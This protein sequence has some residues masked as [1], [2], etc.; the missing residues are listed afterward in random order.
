MISQATPLDKLRNVAG[1]PLSIFALST[2]CIQ[3]DPGQRPK[4]LS[5]VNELQRI[6]G[7][8]RASRPS[9]QLRRADAIRQTGATAAPT[10]NLATYCA[11]TD[12]SATSIDPAASR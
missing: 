12:T 8:V 6:K 1:C 5:I 4:F 10:F 3:T 2:R 11:S 9:A 7:S